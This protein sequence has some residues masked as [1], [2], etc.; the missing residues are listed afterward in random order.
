MFI[1]L[2]LLYAAFIVKHFLYVIIITSMKGAK[3]IITVLINKSEGAAARIKDENIKYKSETLTPA[4]RYVTALTVHI[5]GSEQRRQGWGLFVHSGTAVQCAAL[6]RP[7]GGGELLTSNSSCLRAVCR[8]LRPGR[9]PASLTGP[10]CVSGGHGQV[11]PFGQ[12][13]FSAASKPHPLKA[14]AHHGTA[15]ARRKSTL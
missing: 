11:K 13:S 3:Q 6:Q 4:E 10:L 1:F 15:A 2:I 7:S 14:A 12:T 5:H 8:A 9:G